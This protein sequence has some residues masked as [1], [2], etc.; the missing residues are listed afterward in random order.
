MNEIGCRYRQ[1]L[2]DDEMNAIRQARRRG[3]T[4]SA[5]AMSGFAAL[6]DA[7]L[8]SA[9]GVTYLEASTGNRRFNPSDDA[10]PSD[11]SET[12]LRLL[13]GRLDRRSRTAV[14]MLWFNMGP[15]S[16]EDR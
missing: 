1:R 2:T 15:A 10:I 13:K 7:I 8:G 12:V 9:E 14:G 11:Q 4:G 5:R 3:A 6:W 16:Y